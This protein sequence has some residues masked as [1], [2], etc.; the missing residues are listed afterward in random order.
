MLAIL[1]KFFLGGGVSAL[2]G[3]L[4]DAYEAKVRAETDEQRL[5]AE[6]DISRIQSAIEMAKVANED[7]LSATSI[8]R[9]L[10]VVPFGLWYTLIFLV[11]II[12]PIFGTNLI[13]LDIPPKIW[14][15]SLWLVPVI[16]AGEILPKM[17]LFK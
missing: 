16:V 7:R 4:A 10:I 17:R 12:N 3:R 9:Y 5:A 8:G 14:E 15:I 13:I 2:A 11:S 6:V 1:T